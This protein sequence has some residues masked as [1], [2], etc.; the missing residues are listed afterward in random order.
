VPLFAEGVLWAAA[1]GGEV[2]V[3]TVS[4]S[5]PPED[6]DAVDGDVGY[7]APPSRTGT[8]GSVFTT[9]LTLGPVCR[10][11]IAAATGLSQG[12]VTKLAKQMIDA[13]FVVETA[14]ITTGPGRPLVPLA[15]VAE[16]QFAVGIKVMADQIIAVLVDLSGSVR[17]SIRETLDCRDPEAVI[18]RIVRMTHRLLERVPAP[19]ARIAGVGVGIGGHVDRMTGTIMHSPALH[20]PVFPLGR[21]LQA[22]VGLPVAVEN[23]VNALTLAEEWFGAGRGVRSF[24]LVTIGAGVGAGLVINGELWTGAT[25]AAGEFGHLIVDPEAPRCDC[26]RRGCLQ[27][28]VNDEA[29]ITA[30]SAAL[31]RQ[32]TS[33]DEVYRGAEQGSQPAQ[34][35]IERAGRALGHGLAL[36]LNL[37]NPELVIM[38]GEGMHDSP[39]LMGPLR[40]QLAADAFSST[41]RDCSLL[42]RPMPDEAWAAGAAAS[43]LRIGVLRSLR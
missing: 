6:G 23:D 22:A 10:R 8:I 7:T 32:V 14:S 2:A 36:L 11:D 26:G 16:R 27:S 12:S 31:G 19:A 42:V 35:V 15:V 34:Q 39:F 17:Q 5:A 33:L 3:P 1:E 28:A 43:M 30:A 21:R 41:A 13:G 38:S 24:A 29:I 25:G 4:S 9:V 37:I 18:E 20:W 40:D